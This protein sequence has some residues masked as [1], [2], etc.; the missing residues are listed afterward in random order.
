M[1]ARR[2][3]EQNPQSKRHSILSPLVNLRL[4]KQLSVVLQ[5]SNDRRCLPRY[6]QRHEHAEIA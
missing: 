2:E 4:L 5:A 6:L 1:E 3:K